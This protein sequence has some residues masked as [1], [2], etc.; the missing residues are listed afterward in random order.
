MCM[1]IYAMRSILII[2]VAGAIAYSYAYFGRGNGSIYLSRVG[3]RGSE[4][5]LIDCY[6]RGMGVH[7]CHHSNDAGLRCKRKAT[8]LL[9]TSLLYKS[10]Y[11]R[12][13]Q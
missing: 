2:T 8:S 1:L 12:M 10:I 6:H 11:K 5:R 3:C 4:L 9:H 13:Y 7:Y